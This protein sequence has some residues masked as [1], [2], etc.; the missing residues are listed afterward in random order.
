MARIGM[1]DGRQQKW[2]DFDADTEVLVAFLDKEQIMALRKKGAKQARLSGGDVDVITNRLIGEAGCLG[3]HKK[4]DHNHPGLLTAK[5]VAIPFN[6]AKRD[7]L[8]KGC[9]EFSNFI[10][11][12]AM[13]SAEFLEE[14]I[15]PAELDAAKNG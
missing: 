9:R 13:D 6:D 5:G 7:M 11:D 1:F 8:M 2:I 4:T 15:D 10:N 12:T 14:E 3:W